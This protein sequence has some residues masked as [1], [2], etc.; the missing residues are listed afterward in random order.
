MKR[1]IEARKA[2]YG[3]VQNANVIT[4]LTTVTHIYC[5]MLQLVAQGQSTDQN[6][7]IYRLMVVC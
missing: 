3:V 2:I 4:V 5:Q 6:I 1:E 7:A